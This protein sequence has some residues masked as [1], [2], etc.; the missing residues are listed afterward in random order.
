[1]DIIDNLLS[2]QVQHVF[3]QNKKRQKYYTNAIWLMIV[4]IT[5]ISLEI[6]NIFQLVIVINMVKKGFLIFEGRS[7]VFMCTWKQVR[8]KF[9]IHCK[10]VVAQKKI[11]MAT[12]FF[13]SR[14]AGI[15]DIFFFYFACPARQ[16]FFFFTTGITGIQ[17][18]CCII[19][20]GSEKL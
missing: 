17:F 12:S 14:Q 7:T 1:M 4:L 15:L 16:V 10:S 3:H 8:I 6:D 11:P 18:S 2:V 19:T 20:R 5:F 9:S 13:L